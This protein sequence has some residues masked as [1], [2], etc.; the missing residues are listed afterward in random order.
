M[1]KGIARF[2]VKFRWLVVIAWIAAVP[3]L[4]STLPSITSVTKNNNSD[5]LPKNSPSSQAINLETNF[6]PKDTSDNET[7]IIAREDAALTPSD[8][9]AIG[10]ITQSVKKIKDVTYVRDQGTSADGETL[11]LQVGVGNAAYNDATP[12]VSGI[13][14]ILRSY[15]K[16]GLSVHLAGPLATSVDANKSQSKGKNNTTI[17]TVIFILVLLLIVFRSVLAPLVTILPAGLA[18]AVAQPLIAKATGLGIEVSFITEILL[19][20]LILGAGTDYGLFLVFRTREELRKGLHPKEAVIEALTKVGESITFSAATVGAALISLLMASFGIYKGLGPALAIGLA[21]MLLAG[22]TFLPALLSILG[23]SVFW[24]SK[25]S[26]R[27]Q[28]IGLWGRV[29]DAVI[30]RPVLMISIG[31]VLLGSLSLGIIGYKTA[32]FGNSSAPA[33][34]DSALAQTDIAKHYPK[35]SSQPQ[36]ALLHFDHSIWNNLSILQK[37]QTDLA[38]QPVF[39]TVSGPFTMNGLSLTVQQLEQLHKAGNMAPQSQI[40]SEFISQDGKTVQFFVSGSAGK[41]TSSASIN[42][43]PKLRAAVATV[44]RQVGAT[45]SGIYGADAVGYDINH[46]ATNDLKK[47][48]PIVLIIIAVLLGI[49]L[50]SLVAPLYLIATVAL[51]YLASVGFAMFVFV[52]FLDQ[53]GLN[54]IVAFMLFIFSMALGEDYNILIMSRI[55]EEAHKEKTLKAAVTKAIGITGTTVTSAG[56]ILAG[57]FGV[58]GLVGGNTQIEQIGYSIAFGILLDT[59]FVRTLLV[60]SVVTL[61]GKWNWWPSKLS[62]VEQ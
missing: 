55:R 1:F 51:S 29:A 56:L 28:K 43:T 53:D 16:D 54:F 61:L 39:A 19:V 37:A 42:A 40:L 22:L 15:S 7:I 26:K 31:L 38:E 27:V 41:P 12:V 52:H 20:V 24:P 62:K 47:I 46:S 5:F 8:K 49:M 11:E 6:Q 57:T 2:S 33:G 21:V 48:I 36:F 25:T 18:L 13:R 4:N 45:Q 60:P 34:S 50:R 35:T 9:Q 17:Y 14:S 32:G 30:K 10:T 44:A 59:F 3:I 58:L 23:R